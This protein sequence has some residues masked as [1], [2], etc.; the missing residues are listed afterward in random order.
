M[1]ACIRGFLTIAVFTFVGSPAVGQDTKPLKSH[2]SVALGSTGASP[3]GV[4]IVFPVTSTLDIET[5]V[6]YRRGEGRIHALSTST[7]MLWNLPR[8]GRVAPYLA[9]RSWAGAIWRTGSFTR[10]LSHRHAVARDRDGERWRRVESPGSMRRWTS[11]RCPVVQVVRPSRI[12]ALSRGSG[13]RLRRRQ[14]VISGH[15]RRA[16]FLFR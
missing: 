8:V 3:L 7:S 15:R 2:R 16:Y 11:R 4:A 14:T 5:E 12:G 1:R 9:A 10:W 6:D 13:R